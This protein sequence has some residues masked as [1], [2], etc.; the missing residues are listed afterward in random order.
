MKSNSPPLPAL[1]DG[2]EVKMQRVKIG[3]CYEGIT[4]TPGRHGENEFR[5]EVRK[6]STVKLDRKSGWVWE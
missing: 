2:R 5:W 3:E 6:V 1:L 4:G